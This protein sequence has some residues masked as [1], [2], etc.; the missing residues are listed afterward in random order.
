MASDFKERPRCL[1]RMTGT[2]K[3]GD[4]KQLVGSG[5]TAQPWTAPNQSSASDSS[6]NSKRM[7][8]FLK[9]PLAIDRRNQAKN[10]S[11]QEL[12]SL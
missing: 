2:A 10:I 11:C 6:W 5:A 3:A 4:V 9:G 1:I 8:G 12:R 7:R